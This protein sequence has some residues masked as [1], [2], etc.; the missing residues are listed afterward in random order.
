ML[1]SVAVLTR[2]G[3]AARLRGPPT[4]PNRQAA[5]LKPSVADDPEV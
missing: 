3:L 2:H 1:H 5:E 4:A